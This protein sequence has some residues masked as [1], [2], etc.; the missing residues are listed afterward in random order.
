MKLNTDVRPAAIS[1]TQPF[2]RMHRTTTGFGEQLLDKPYLKRRAMNTKVTIWFCVG[3]LLATSIAGFQNRRTPEEGYIEA[4]KQLNAEEQAV[5]ELENLGGEFTT[6]PDGKVLGVRFLDDRL[7]DADLV[8]LKCLPRLYTINLNN[9]QVTDAGL[10]HLKGLTNLKSLD[11][12]N[13]Q[14]TDT[15][16][17][18]LKGLIGL[19]G[20]HLD[21][22]QVTD[23]GLE[24][25]KGLTRLGTISLHDTQVTDIGIKKLQKALP[26]CVIHH[27]LRRCS[28]QWRYPRQSE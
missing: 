24:H 5:A 9:T 11:L 28:E 19:H 16:L 2:F 8:H 27:L 10:M 7:T 15:G 21:N 20:L 4:I 1:S 23:T 22:T 26:N 6:A 18:H 12:N 13:T 14:I 17:V 25:L 3:F